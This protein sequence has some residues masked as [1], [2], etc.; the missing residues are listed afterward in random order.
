ML[1]EL[2]TQE[3]PEPGHLLAHSTYGV[4]ITRK[5]TTQISNPNFQPGHDSASRFAYNESQHSL[6]VMW[7][8]KAKIVGC[9]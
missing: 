2:L 3:V 4:V 9:T 8:E 6:V 1:S 5:G 7:E